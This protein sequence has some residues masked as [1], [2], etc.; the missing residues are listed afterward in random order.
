MNETMNAPP[1]PV[2]A[3]APVPVPAYKNKKTRVHCAALDRNNTICRR[4]GMDNTPFCNLHAHLRGC[5]PEQLAVAGICTG[6][7]IRFYSDTFLRCEKCQARSKITNIAAKAAIVHCAFA[8][9]KYKGAPNDKY[10]LKHTR[11]HFVDETVAKGMKVCFNNIRGC[12]AQLAAD[13]LYTRCGDCLAADR[14]NDRGRRGNA[15]AAANVVMVGG[16]AQPDT[17]VCTTCCKPQQ[18][19][20]FATDKGVRTKTCVV[21]RMANKVQNAK[22]DRAHRNKS[23]R[24]R[25]A[26]N[27][28]SH[29]VKKE[30]VLHN[31]AKIADIWRAFRARKRAK[32]GDEVYLRENAD[33]AQKWRDANPSLMEAQYQRNKDS[34]E[35]QY[36][37]YFRKARAA[38]MEFA[39]SF[40]DFVAV[41]NTPCEYCGTLPPRGFCGVDRIDN[42]RGYVA[43]NCASCCSMCNYMKGDE[44]VETLV[45][46]AEHILTHNR[47]IIGGF[48]FPDEFR[49]IKSVSFSTMVHSAALRNYTVEIEPT[50]Y[51]CIVNKPCYICGKMP[52]Y[53][54]DDMNKVHFNGI[55]RF[56]NDEGYTLSN[57]RSCCTTCNCLKRNYT[58][59]ATMQKLS[60]IYGVSKGV[61][62]SMNGGTTNTIVPT[63]KPKR[64]YCKK[65]ASSLA[66]P[67]RAEKDTENVPEPTLQQKAANAEDQRR[68]VEKKKAALGDE[69]YREMNA[70]R[71]AVQR[72]K[73]PPNPA[74]RAIERAN[75][76][77]RNPPPARAPPKT[78]T[79]R[80]REYQERKKAELGDEAY[81]EMLAAKKAAVRK[82]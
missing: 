41:V 19:T 23:A 5:T 76:K 46:R 24:E 60:Q 59:D 44:S 9:C 66:R 51:N 36:R 52:C 68:F 48:A 70:A 82:T 26:A 2:L 55:D 69:A 79:E 31:R 73:N 34:R 38:D 75:Q 27:P 3:P 1:V 6:C 28:E 63:C 53:D 49:N 37:I 42:T 43:G 29:E 77:A 54:T 4:Y 74:K 15:A 8:G 81:R 32:L 40:D 21:C 64:Q 71:R 18:S 67:P 11:Q 62:I 22:R 25:Y 7:H 45:R 50:D 35:F 16:V 39:I 80:A 57:V 20:W 72:A 65:P 12:N 30:W 61:Y 78:G 14:D 58:F 47:V 56:N 17:Q 10:C 13:Y 33:A